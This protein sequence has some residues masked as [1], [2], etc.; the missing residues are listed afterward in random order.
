MATKPVLVDINMNNNEIQNVVLQNLSSTPTS[1]KAGKIWYNSV[2][3]LVYFH[4]GTSAIPVGYLPPATTATL[5]GVIVGTNIAVASDGTISVASA[6]NAIAG[7]LRLAT[8]AE[9]STGTAEGVAVNPKQLASA[10]ATALVGA[11]VYKGTWA[12]TTST[13]DFSGITLPVKQGYMYAVTGTGPA[14]VGGIEWNPGDYLVIDADVPAGGTITQVHKIDNSEASD[15]V[16]LNTTQTITNKTINADNNTITNLETD[17]F[18]SGV[19]RTSSDGIRPASSASDT[20]LVTEKAVSSAGYIT[21]FSVNNPSLSSSS[22]V[23]TWTVTNTIGSIDV[24]VFVRE[25]SSNEIVQCDITQTASTITIKMNSSNT[26][27]AGTYSAI[28]IG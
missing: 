26:I 7:I 18:K 8:D 1:V 13:T 11:L 22:G 20:C 6:T 12:I 4:N 15:I 28:V 21:K 24:G 9:A 14:T 19:V 2:D 10:I 16:R 17:N 23:C 5:G 3:N 27:P 25:I